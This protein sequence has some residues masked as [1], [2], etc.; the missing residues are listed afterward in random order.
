M[1]YDSTSF[2]GAGG[3]VKEPPS[4]VTAFVLELALFHL[5]SLVTP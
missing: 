5:A 2:S 3:L 1:Q 4:N